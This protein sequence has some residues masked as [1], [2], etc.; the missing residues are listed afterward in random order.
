MTLNFND[1]SFRPCHKRDDVIQ[2]INK[3]SNHRPNLIKHLS[4]SIEKRPSDNSS[5]EKIFKESAIY[6]EDT[7]NK[8]GYIDKLVYHA[9]AQVTRKTK[10]KIA[11]GVLYGLTY[12]IVKVSQRE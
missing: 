8:A 1:G 11:N 10:T 6:Y 9:P 4:A 3:E 5:D 12:H 2:Y 7:F